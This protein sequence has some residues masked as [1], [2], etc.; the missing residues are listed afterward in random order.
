VTAPGVQIL[1]GAADRPAP[2]TL[3]RPGFLFQS[4]Q[5]TSMASPHVTGAAALYKSTHP[6][7]TP[8]EVR[9]ALRDAGTQD[10]NTATDRDAFHEPLLSVAGL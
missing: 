3:L 2:T 9:T 1:A 6:A 7:A 8:A 5:G 10:W 4:I